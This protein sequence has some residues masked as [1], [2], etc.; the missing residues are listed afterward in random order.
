M[1]RPWF[2]K[3][4]V[5]EVDV[6]TFFD[7][8]G[9][10]VGDFAGLTSKLD[11]IAGLG[12]NT[13]WL[14][15]FYVSPGA[16]DGYDVADFY[17][18]DPALG[19][20]GDFVVFLEEAKAVGLRVVVELIVNHT[21]DRHPWFQDAL[22][23]RDAD[24][25]D[26]YI[27][28]D[29]PPA[30]SPERITFTE[31]EAD[32]PSP[33]TYHAGTDQY[34]LHRFYAHEPDLDHSN[35]AVQDELF[36]I[37][38]TW[39]ALGVDGFRI[40][41]AP[42]IA[43][44]AV[45]EERDADPH[46]FLRR[47]RSHIADRN[48]RAILMA[49]ADVDATELGD[50]FGE[51]DEMHLV[52]SFLASQTVFLAL[53]RQSAGPLK[54]ML[55]VLPPCLPHGAYANFLRNHDELDLERLSE[56][57]RAFVF[58]TFAPSPDMRI[59][60][61]GIRRRPAPML[62]PGVARLRLAQS[63]I[64]SLPGIPV[65]RYGDEIGMGDDMSLPDRASVRTPMQW[66]DADNGGFSTAQPPRLYYPMLDGDYGYERVNVAEQIGDPDS[67]LNWTVR[68]VHARRHSRAMRSG[69]W[70]IVD[71]GVDEVLGLRYVDG[72]ETMAVFHNLCRSD[73]CVSLD[74]S[75]YHMV[76]GSESGSKFDGEMLRLER[77]GYA[78]LERHSPSA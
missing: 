68:L 4:V 16:D 26:F 27:W 75:G 22:M 24:H 77:F 66:N 64:F 15:P 57:D 55:E 62:G 51:G 71:T 42:Y 52:L 72:D 31:E 50:Y 41:A 14:N 48:P 30:E 25:R 7:S 53:G 67:Q 10:G 78:W 37:M 18:V 43:E 29:E 8:D 6:R 65:L 60:G 44:K 59:F 9:D 74:G 61:R 19:S 35:Q 28:A 3:A 46:A 49:E 5:Y 39:L 56:E 58:D 73:R 34:Y 11:Y 76:F 63:L 23:G 69:D 36:E 13:I 33:W 2:T 54:R 70:A 21:S 17:G 12:V 32:A 40:D 38:S 20:L 47:M 1:V 45:A